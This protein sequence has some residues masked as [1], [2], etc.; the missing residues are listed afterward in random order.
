MQTKNRTLSLRQN[1]IVVALLV[2]LSA[3]NLTLCFAPVYASAT[4]SI[5]GYPV[6][7][8]T[9][10][11]SENALDELVGTDGSAHDEEIDNADGSEGTSLID[12]P[13]TPENDLPDISSS[14]EIESDFIQIISDTA[15]YDDGI[16]LNA[17]EISPLI[18]EVVLQNGEFEVSGGISGAYDSLADAV[19]AINASADGSYT[20]S[21]NT[22]EV[23][24]SELTINAGK[25]VTITSAGGATRRITQL[26]PIRHFIVYGGL[27]L[28]DIVIDGGSSGFVSGGIELYNQA[29]TLTLR[30][31][32]V[33]ENCSASIGGAVL[34]NSGNLTL[35]QGSAIRSNVAA[36]G[37]GVYVF[38]GNI[39]M[40]GGAVTA[41]TALSVGGGVLF[42]SVT[43]PYT[44]NMSGGSI[45]ANS[46]NDGGGVYVGANDF[47]MSG[48]TIS[49][50]SATS[51]GGGVAI[52]N[53][54]SFH[55][56]GGIIGG[57]GAAANTAFSGGGIA[58][59]IET[60]NSLIISDG[61]IVGN[62]ATEGG[63]IS[64]LAGTCNIVGG[65]ISNNVALLRGG[66]VYL[67]SSKLNMIAGSVTGNASEYGHGGGIFT[68]D[69]H[70]SDPVSL[71]GYL[72]I[73]ISDEAD[74]SGNT[75]SV[76]RLPPS[77]EYELT[78]R[79][80]NAFDGLLLD[81][82]NINYNNTDFRIIYRANR[83]SNQTGSPITTVRSSGSALMQALS[84]SESGF[85]DPETGKSFAGWNTDA[86]GEGTYY[87]AG[88]TVEVPDDV[89]AV[90]V[91]GVYHD[92]ISQVRFDANGGLGSMPAL[93]VAYGQ[94]LTLSN[95][96]FE[97]SG[98]SFTG[99][100]T[101]PS[102]VGESYTD[103]FAFLPWLSV[104]DITLYAQWQ[105]VS[106]DPI[107]PTGKYTVSYLPGLHGTFF[108]LF[109][110]DIASGSP[111]PAAPAATGEEGWRFAG[112]SPTWKLT[113]SA[114]ATYTA[115]W[116]RFE[117]PLHTVR[118]VDWNGDLLKEE[119]VPDGRSATAPP[120]PERLGYTFVEWSEDFT[121]ISADVTIMA[122]YKVYVPD[123]ITTF[124]PGENPEEPA[125]QAPG[126]GE[127]DNQVITVFVRQKSW[128]V[129]NLAL[130]VLGGAWIFVVG[131]YIILR[132][133]GRFSAKP[134][135]AGGEG[136]EVLGSG[137][138]APVDAGRLAD[139]T[140][141]YAEA[142]ISTVTKG[143]TTQRKR[144]FRWLVVAGAVAAMG[145]AIFSFTQDMSSPM[146]LVDRWTM[147]SVTVL[148]FE[149]SCIV[150]VF[151]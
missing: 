67:N 109:Y 82:S 89:R 110:S 133:T 91:Y 107:S 38:Q 7:A 86:N 78:G 64:V 10:I 35:L 70:Y 105:L 71:A 139:K 143:I 137:R 115:Q 13:T 120:D 36:G 131:G 138:E 46:A 21:I 60:E 15:N 87:Q 59:A 45:S 118:F 63:G 62:Q 149:V 144:Q 117:T 142:P 37:G 40:Q 146:T 47:M 55:L 145:F 96:S 121:N 116:V 141:F 44:F 1:K 114:N 20:I 69:Y 24:S 88:D 125:E 101:S 26:N 132:E 4:G 66:G 94:D 151:R 65:N 74:V 51:Y 56:S 14:E 6:L 34:I 112:W 104:G 129:V 103:G 100:N 98:Y 18:N 113:V 73:S 72:N 42:G 106:V 58:V 130:S 11:D 12:D 28:I 48:G 134:K 17:N 76:R 150:R 52:W 92:I 124:E 33:I 119:Q 2:L 19:G 85:A 8:D 93:A 83:D 90:V 61:S 147:V 102:G 39:D 99:W 111:T 75:A 16:A 68:Q 148:A 25:Q 53:H 9:V 79:D 126:E 29:A 122:L 30:S 95:N 135:D 57:Y 23:L 80:D 108:P 27:N 54:S 81:N 31:G 123:P 50:N 41:N 77:N 136:G 128:A 140:E 49:G 32:A 127:Q 3:F 97:R 5:Q 43:G 22:D 84:L